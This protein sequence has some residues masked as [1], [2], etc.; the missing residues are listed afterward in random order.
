MHC[1][2]DGEK[3]DAS[4]LS[5]KNERSNNNAMKKLVLTPASKRLHRSEIRLYSSVQHSIVLP[6][7]TR[8]FA[9]CLARLKLIDYIT[10]CL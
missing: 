2:G 7:P 3:A 1:F 10:A 8:T 4:L 9:H 5:T 6:V